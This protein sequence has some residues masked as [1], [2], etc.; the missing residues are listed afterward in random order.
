MQLSLYIDTIVVN[1]ITFAHLD[2][3][4]LIF[5]SLTVSK[6]YY[7]TANSFHRF[8]TSWVFPSNISCFDVSS[9]YW[10]PVDLLLSSIPLMNQL[11]ELYI[12]DTQLSLIHLSQ[13]FEQCKNISTLGFTVIEETL[14]DIPVDR[15]LL[16]QGFNQLTCIKL[17]AVNA[18]Y[19]IDSWLVPL[20]LLR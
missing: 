13:I 10:L 12:Q 11:N 3:L 9:C 15:A 6:C 14:D 7:L 8:F 16:V 19:Y 5:R 4:S 2:L 17:Y 20:A 18:T 1:Q